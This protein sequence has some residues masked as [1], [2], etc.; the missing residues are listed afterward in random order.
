MSDAN[1][2]RSVSTSGLKTY[3]F[4]VITTTAQSK[5]TTTL[6]E[7][8]TTTDA[9]YQKLNAGYLHSFAVNLTCGNDFQTNGLFVYLRSSNNADMSLSETLITC[10]CA[11]QNSVTSD[12][13]FNGNFITLPDKYYAFQVYGATD[14]ATS[15]VIQATGLSAVVQITSVP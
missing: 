8:T 12:I 11:Y 4:E 6:I 7:Y 1:C 14:V 13:C 2:A 15:F 5:A 10:P 9:G 3:P